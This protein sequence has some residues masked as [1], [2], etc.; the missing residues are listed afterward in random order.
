MNHKFSKAY[1]FSDF[2]MIKIIV[3]LF[4]NPSHNNAGFGFFPLKLHII[5]CNVHLEI[6]KPLD[7][8]NLARLWKIHELLM[9]K[10]T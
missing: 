7:F 8:Q 6:V 5:K 10:L 9:L 2:I 1:L 3:D 4:L